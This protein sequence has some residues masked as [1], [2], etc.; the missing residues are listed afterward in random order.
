MVLDTAVLVAGLRSKRGASFRLLEMVAD[1]RVLPLASTALYLE[2]E[3]V[4]KRPEHLAAMHLSA[5]DVDDLLSGLSRALQPV[6]LHYTWRPQ[7]RDP[8]DE[9]VL[10]VAVNG[11][12]DFI[13]THNIRDF[14]SASALFEFS[15][16]T[17]GQLL[18]RIIS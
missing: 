2:Y 5:A 10:E 15:V 7:L 12:A 6:H 4:L 13:V 3:A 11:G 9:L 8:G 1:R 18:S 17:P 16:C 14:G